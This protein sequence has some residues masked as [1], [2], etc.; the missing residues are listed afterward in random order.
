MKKYPV[1]FY[2]DKMQGAPKMVKDGSAVLLSILKPVLVTG[3]G[4]MVCDSLVFD[5]GKGWAKATFAN[6]HAYQKHSVI[7]ING[8]SVEDYNGE[9]RVMLISTNDVWF[10]LDTAPTGDATG[11][12][13]KYPSLNWEVTHESQ[14]GLQAIFRPKGDLTDVSL[15][16]DNSDYNV[17][18]GKRARVIMVTNVVD[19]DTWERCFTATE[20]YDYWASHSTYDNHINGNGRD[21]HGWELFGNNAFFNYFPLA[22]YQSY[23]ADGYSAGAFNSE[24][25]A[26]RFNFMVRGG[27]S[28][29]WSLNG[30]A[31]GDL[32]NAIGCLIAREHHQL[33]GAAYGMPVTLFGKIYK[34]NA[35]ASPT[36]S[37]N[38]IYIIDNEIM[39]MCNSTASHNGADFRGTLP[40][41]REIM[42][43]EHTGIIEKN[44]KLFYLKDRIS[45]QSHQSNSDSYQSHWAFDISTVEG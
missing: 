36:L 10:E 38:G 35:P 41:V 20:S 26:D 3:F 17:T 19:I 43:I 5:S 42:T 21:D 16:V 27:G 23:R 24:R 9:H 12:S 7:E 45:S 37:N 14:D 22:M 44:G 32:K 15:Y 13:M 4:E 2:N 34:S 25:P 6:G 40:I 8:A 18:Y 11:A 33:Q 31:W 30:N 29:T 28:K 39:L 1:K